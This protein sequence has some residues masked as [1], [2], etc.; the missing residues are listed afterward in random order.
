MLSLKVVVSFLT[1]AVAMDHHLDS[2]QVSVMSTR[3]SSEL[4]K[5]MTMFLQVL[6]DLGLI[7]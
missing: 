2:C 7:H 1:S 5:R 6:K 4:K 3:S